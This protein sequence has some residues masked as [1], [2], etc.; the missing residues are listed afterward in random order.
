MLVI[1]DTFIMRLTAPKSEGGY[2]LVELLVTMALAAVVFGAIGTAL[3]VSQRT[4]ARDTERVASMEEARTGLARIAREIRQASS[5]ELKEATTSAISFIA[6]IGGTEREI[7]YN[8]AEKNPEHSEYYECVRKESQAGKQIS[9]G[10]YIRDLR[11]SEVFAYFKGA[12][13]LTEPT[14]S[15]TANAV[16]MKVEM[17]LQGTLKQVGKSGYQGNTALENT[18]FIRNR[19]TEG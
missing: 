19:D 7:S 14:E 9:S 8:C 6:V 12:A 4:E 17:P 3:D 13:K 2:T 11:K 16:T 10:P 5:A 1:I 18:A 15:K